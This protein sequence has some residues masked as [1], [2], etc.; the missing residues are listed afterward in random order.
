MRRFG[1]FH[2]KETRTQTVAIAIVQQATSEIWGATPRNGG[3][4]PTVQAY[5]GLLPA[6]R[7][8]EFSTDISIHPGSCPIEARWY[9]GLT[10]GVEERRDSAGQIFACISADVV[11]KQP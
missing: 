2:R 9:L 11:N 4:V 5:P 6:C 1:P 10:H 8:V 7:G 3:M